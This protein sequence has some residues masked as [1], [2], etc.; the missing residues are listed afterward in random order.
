M[1]L[2][3]ETEETDPAQQAS[4]QRS[5]LPFSVTPSLS[6][7]PLTLS[8]SKIHRLP[9]F[10]LGA[11]GSHKAIFHPPPPALLMLL[12]LRLCSAS[13]EQVIAIKRTYQ[14][15]FNPREVF[16]DKI[17]CQG[18]KAK[19]SLLLYEC[20]VLWESVC[21]YIGWGAF[22]WVLLGHQDRMQRCNSIPAPSHLTYVNVPSN[23]LC[24]SYV[25]WAV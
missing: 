3:G 10:L 19:V 7:S 24:I 14:A 25:F 5:S 13:P 8:L 1:P 6:S 11:A 21:Q 12:L 20:I 22:V 17:P 15:T 4:G 9:Q 23:F 2:W 16:L 18:H